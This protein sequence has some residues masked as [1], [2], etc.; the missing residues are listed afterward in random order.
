[1]TAR[2]LSEQASSFRAAEKRL[3]TS[4]VLATQHVALL[5]PSAIKLACEERKVASE[6]HGRKGRMVCE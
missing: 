6:F 2:L 4:E 3:V 1:M 5:L